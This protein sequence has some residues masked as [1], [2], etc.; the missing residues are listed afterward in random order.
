MLV[1]NVTTVN[2]LENLPENSVII[3]LED[4]VLSVYVNTYIT[5]YYYLERFSTIG[6][7]NSRLNYYFNITARNIFAYLD[8]V[9]KLIS[10]GF[11]TNITVERL[12]ISVNRILTSNITKTVFSFKASIRLLNERTCMLR[13]NGSDTLMNSSNGVIHKL[14]FNLNLGDCKSKYIL[15]LT[16]IDEAVNSLFKILY[17]ISN[18]TVILSHSKTSL[19]AKL[20][21][22][23][24][25]GEIIYKVTKPDTMYCLFFSKLGMPR[26]LF[27][28]L[29]KNNISINLELKSSMPTNH[30]YISG[31]LSIKPCIAP[32]NE[33]G[34]KLLK[35]NLSYN[36]L[37]YSIGE[38][39]LYLKFKTLNDSK[40]LSNTLDKLGKL[41]Y[42][43]N[44]VN[45]DIVYVKLCSKDNLKIRIPPYI[46]RPLVFN[47]SYAEWRG[48]SILRY[49]GLVELVYERENN[50]SILV[51]VIMLVAI[52]TLTLLRM[53]KRTRK[54]GK[55][56]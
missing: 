50:N 15:L 18:K 20:T 34:L 48:T 52:L 14:S 17:N 39:T 26:N 49:L 22:V 29:A 9:V 24:I 6:S 37:G 2:K 36:S 35:I 40:A 28:Y 30:T 7:C 25:K 4:K 43:L 11:I 53:F 10:Q 42:S 3:Q 27:N 19:K 56:E 31:K 51:V 1:F 23:E 54:R 46:P 33:S 8:K 12:Q 21:G 38:L 44:Y 45:P 13:V 41:L 47:S 16:N 55:L 32:I 5:S